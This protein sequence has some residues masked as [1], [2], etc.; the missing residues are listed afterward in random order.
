MQGCSVLAD[1]QRQGIKTEPYFGLPDAV[2]RQGF[3]YNG[4]LPSGSYAFSKRPARVVVVVLWSQ[5]RLEVDRRTGR[6]AIIQ[7]LLRV[8]GLQRQL[9]GRAVVHRCGRQPEMGSIHQG[10][11]VGHTPV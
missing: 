1:G 11:G 4:A 3:E 6:C 2:P 7:Q 8:F 9:A 10:S 5:G